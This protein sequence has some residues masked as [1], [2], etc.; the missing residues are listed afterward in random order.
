MPGQTNTL[1]GLVRRLR[2]ERGWTLKQMSEQVA[3]PLST[4]AKV[5]NDK[6]SLTYD[7]LQQLSSR[8]DM[9]MTEFLGQGDAPAPELEPQIVTGRR[10][11][12]GRD[13]V[14]QIN[15]PNYGYEYLCTDLNEKRM[16]PILTR[17]RAHS[18]AEFGDP[19]RHS[20][21][22]FV[23]VLEGAIEVHLQFYK[24]IRLEVGQGV[25]LDSTMGHAYTAVDC[26]SALMLAVCSSEDLSLEH[27][28]M[29]AAEVAPALAAAPAAK[30]ARG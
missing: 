23:Y 14:I 25:Y 10:S 13:N 17:V 1:G 26:D 11:V 28:L 16:V 22:E 27:E 18:L 4:L 7:K 29:Q 8:L 24:P 9:T 30:G 6:L 2:Q 15:T 5:E 12:M 21:E 19:V 3:I 20:G